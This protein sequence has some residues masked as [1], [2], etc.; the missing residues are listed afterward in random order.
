MK[1][2]YAKALNLLSGRDIMNTKTEANAKQN[3]ITLPN[4]LTLLRIVGSIILLFTAPFT[5][6]FFTVYTLTGITDILDG[7]TAR[8]TCGET[9]FGAKLDSAADLIFYSCLLIKILPKLLET[10]SPAIWTVL[11]GVILLRLIIY[12]M[13]I[14]KYHR[15]ASIH[16][17]LNK[18]TSIMVFFIAYAMTTEYAL[19]YCWAALTV[20]VLATIE[21]LLIHALSKEYTSRKKSIFI[22][23]P[24]ESAAKR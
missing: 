6:V 15:F 19:G 10:L 1:R 4:I 9:E 18:L 16:S 17:Y 14:I 21:E 13:V 24:K 20:A 12:I 23:L 3:I 22:K 2:L 5:G 7:F 11:G 8:L